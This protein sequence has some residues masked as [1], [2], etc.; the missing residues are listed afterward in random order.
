MEK[1]L[2]SG[3]DKFRCICSNRPS[4]V[5]R[6]ASDNH[7]QQITG[8]ASP[9]ASLPPA[10][11]LFKRLSQK[12]SAVSS[13]PATAP[14]SL[15]SPSTTHSSPLLSNNTLSVSNSCIS[16]CTTSNETSPAVKLPPRW[17]QR[18]NSSDIDDETIIYS[19]C[20]KTDQ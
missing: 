4:I 3:C 17:P 9:A 1:L 10:S 6:P 7:P 19:N 11:T 18:S 20:L 12:I 13:V 2:C 5:S 8:A 14:P 15:S 16:N